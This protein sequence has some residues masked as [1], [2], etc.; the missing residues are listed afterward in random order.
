MRF[1]TVFAVG[2]HCPPLTHEHLYESSVKLQIGSTS[3]DEGDGEKF[4]NDDG[5]SSSN[6]DKL[7][8]V[9]IQA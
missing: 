8:V 5:E 1:K 3:R 2:L 6:S 9:E 4:R 7:S